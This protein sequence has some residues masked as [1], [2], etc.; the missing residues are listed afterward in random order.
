M[1]QSSDWSS[2]CVITGLCFMCRYVYYFRWSA[3]VCIG[4]FSRMYVW[5]RGG[6]S[7]MRGSFMERHQCLIRTGNIAL[8]MHMV[9]AKKLFCWGLN[10]VG[11]WF[12]A[13]LP[14]NCWSP[15]SCN[16]VLYSYQ[17]S[18]ASVR[19]ILCMLIMLLFLQQLSMEKVILNFLFSGIVVDAFCG[20]IADQF[21]F[22]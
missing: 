15:L 17:L 9:S 6:V 11:L 16:M 8:E 18:C 14:D 7:V 22:E 1:T 20:E 4:C 21:P 19:E 13:G 12:S 3:G 2:R 5:S 10:D